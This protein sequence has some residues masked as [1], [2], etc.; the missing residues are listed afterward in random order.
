MVAFGSGQGLSD[1]ETAVIAGYFEGSAKASLRAQKS[2]NAAL[3]ESCRLWVAQVG[4]SRVKSLRSLVQCL[5][6]LA[7]LF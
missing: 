5:E 4:K 2:A 1:F 3:A 6:Y 7:V